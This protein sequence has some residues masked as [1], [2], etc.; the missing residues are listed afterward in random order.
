[1][2][3]GAV[4]PVAAV[5]EAPLIVRRSEHGVEGSVEC[6]VSVL[7]RFE[8]TVDVRRGLREPIRQADGSER[9]GWAR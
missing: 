4:V 3:G 8:A 5:G 6:N 2:D 7:E 9:R 1:M